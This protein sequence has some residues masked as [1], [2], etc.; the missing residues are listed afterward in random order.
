MVPTNRL[1]LANL[2]A[3]F[4]PWPLPNYPATYQFWIQRDDMTGSTLSGNKIRKLEFLLADALAQDCDT[5]ITCGGIQSNHAR[6]TAVA[7]AQLGIQSHL[8]LRT[9]DTNQEPGLEGN[10]LLDRL[11]GATLHLISPDEYAKREEVMRHKA[12]ELETEGKRPYVIPEGGSNALGTWGYIEAVRE[13]VETHEMDAF[14]ITDIVVAL[15]SG[16][17]VAGLAAGLQLLNSPIRIHAVNVCDDATH[18]HTRIQHIFDDLGIA[19]R[20]ENCI[21]IMEGYVGSGYAQVRQD[22]LRY[23]VDIACTTGIILDPVY[24]G[25]AF[26]GLA[27][28]IMQHPS[29]F[30]GSRILFIHTGGLFGLFPFRSMLPL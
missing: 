20:S 28:E 23:L 13:L 10:L 24:T 9:A 6:A 4:E 25:K 17:T 26:H 3:P 12:I 15:G 1:H 5:I 8:F 18:F 21:D 16:G 7:T 29:R 2:P 27:Q 14:G 30:Q 19:A 11:T 22:E